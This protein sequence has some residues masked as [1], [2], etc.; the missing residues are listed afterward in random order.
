M[1]SYFLVTFS[2]FAFT[3]CHVNFIRNDRAFEI[4]M[5]YDFSVGLNEA[6]VDVF[7]SPFLSSAWTSIKVRKE[8]E[9]R[10]YDG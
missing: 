3:F 4:F 5:F 8:H 2:F 7:L 1:S 10:K 6:F 9:R